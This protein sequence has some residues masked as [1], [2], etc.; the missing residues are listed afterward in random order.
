MIANLLEI[1]LEDL[2][3]EVSGELDV[4][5]CLAADPKVRVGFER[6][7]CRVRIHTAEGTDPLRIEH[8]TAAVERYCVNLDTLIGGID[9][10]TTFDAGDHAG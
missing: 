3:V 8:L 5:G 1:E 6:L 7:D 9:V 2:E 4:R 10:H